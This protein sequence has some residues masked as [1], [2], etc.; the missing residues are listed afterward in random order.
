MRLEGQSATMARKEDAEPVSAQCEFGT[1]PPA[2][3]R[4]NLMLMLDA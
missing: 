4:G 1:L 2:P 3:Q